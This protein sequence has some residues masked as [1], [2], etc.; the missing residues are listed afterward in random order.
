MVNPHHRI[1]NFYT[2]IEKKTSVMP[3]Y[4][5][6]QGNHG[7]ICYR[8]E[9]KSDHGDDE[10]DVKGNNP[11]DDNNECGY[12]SDD[13]LPKE[14]V[15]DRLSWRTGDPFAN[16]KIAIIVINQHIP[17]ETESLGGNAKNH[18]IASS[19]TAAGK[20]KATIFHV[21][22]CVLASGPRRSDYFVRLFN[23][24]GNFSESSRNGTSRIKLSELQAKAFP[25]FL[26]YVYS[27]GH[28][29]VFSTDTATALYSLAKHFGTARLKNEAKH[30]CLQDMRDRQRCGTYYEHATILQE[31]AI[32]E[33]AAKFCR[34]HITRI[35]FK[36]SRLLHVPDPQFW[37]NMMK[38]R[39]EKHTT[40]TSNC[41]YSLISHIAVFSYK[42]AGTLSPDAFWQLTHETYLP[43]T[44]IHPVNAMLLL[45]AER[46]I[47]ANHV[48]QQQQGDHHEQ[49]SSLQIR[50]VNA[51]ACAEQQELRRLNQKWVREALKKLPPVVLGEIISRGLL[52]SPLA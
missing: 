38:D 34:D 20:K 51:I 30:F 19:H 11:Q 25:V 52:L 47:V 10:E 28:P 26:D 1:R 24:D 14:L 22:K 36:S 43:M 13:E 50:C 29:M 21:R 41:K 23:N 6:P 48:G 42:H 7:G 32:R 15:K 44:E 37:I 27:T 8:H 39:A 5:R 3:S 45:D 16:W 33:P 4:Q 40:F 9:G 31:N 46:R 18:D 49:L 35:D 17:Q 2:T 12:G